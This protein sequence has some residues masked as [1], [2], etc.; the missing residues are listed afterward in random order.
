MHFDFKHKRSFH[1]ILQKQIQF[2]FS[3]PIKR[4]YK[5]F[6]TTGFKKSF[7]A[8]CDK[9]YWNK[10]EYKSWIKASFPFYRKNNLNCWLIDL[11][12][13]P[14]STIFQSYHGDKFTY[15]CVSWFSHTSTPHN[16]L[17]KQLA[18][19]QQTVKQPIG[20]RQV[21]QVTMTS[22]KHRKE[23]WPSRDLNSQPLDCPPASLPTR[24]VTWPGN[25][26]I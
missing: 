10:C 11:G 22:V 18:A 1:L 15:S 24:L 14:F 17:S 5:N 9:F 26:M 25:D 20:E 19:F 12:L 6:A 3:C 7:A 2:Y 23:C 16:I 13:T 4:F 8:L 21:T